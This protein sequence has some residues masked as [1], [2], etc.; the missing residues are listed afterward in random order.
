MRKPAAKGID[1]N[2]YVAFMLDCFSQAETKDTTKGAFR[3]L[4]G[5]QS[6][7]TEEQLDK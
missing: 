7:I 2:G 4:A 5:N 6:T 1:F 3:G